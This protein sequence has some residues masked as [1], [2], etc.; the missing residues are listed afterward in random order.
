MEKQ[1]YTQNNEYEELILFHSFP[2]R[3]FENLKTVSQDKL[4]KQV[5]F[6]IRKAS[7]WAMLLFLVV[8]TAF[9]STGCTK[10]SDNPEHQTVSGVTVETI[11]KASVDNYYETSATVKAKTNSVIASMITGKVTSLAVQEGDSVRAGQLL[12]TIDSRDTAQRAIGANAGISA[13]QMGAQQAAQNKKMADVTYQ[14]YKSLYNEKVITKQEFDQYSTQKNVAALEYQKAQAG[15]QQARAGLGEVQVY[16][17]YSRV[18]APISGI[19]TQR[20]IDLGST[21][22]QGQPILTIESPGN[23]ELV[24]NVD[25]S[26]LK[27]IHKGEEVNLVVDG[28]TIKTKITTIVQSVD[29]TTRTFKLKLDTKGLSSGLYAKVQIPVGKKDAIAVPQ[30]AI[31]QKGQLTGVYTVDDKNIISYRLIRTGKTLGDK[32]EVISGLTD[33]DKVITSGV[34]KAVDGGEIK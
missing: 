23:Q 14:R 5:S 2:S 18:T 10:H 22:I 19:V 32:V 7:R 30:V 31:V 28:K 29:P 13:A 34:E 26:Y 3:L 4:K 6:C 33:G 17:S 25:E 11:S 16:Q 27:K 20:N 12:L 9:V 21:A 15:V 1:F 24:A 8:S